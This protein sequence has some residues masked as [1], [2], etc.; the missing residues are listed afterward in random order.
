M[1]VSHRKH[2]YEP[3]RPVTVIAL[4]FIMWIMF[5]S[6]RKH[7]Y[8]NPRPV[9]GIALLHMWIM[10]VPHRKHTYGNPRPFTGIALLLHMWIMLVP[11]RKHLW[12]STACNGD[13]FFT[14][15]RNENLSEF[16][17]MFLLQKWNDPCLKTGQ[18]KSFLINRHM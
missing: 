18:N 12:E 4:F 16:Q 15:I 9:T 11:H 1:L 7:T 13:R 2:T 8:G 10:F 17:P 6:H 5:V 14:C 3:P